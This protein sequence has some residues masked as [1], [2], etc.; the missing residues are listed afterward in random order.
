MAHN[1]APSDIVTHTDEN[2]KPNTA[3]P[4]DVTTK[5][6]PTAQSKVSQEL[7]NADSK[8]LKNAIHPIFQKQNW[9][10][11]AQDAWPLLEPALRLASRLIS[12]DEMLAFWYHLVW[13][14]QKLQVESENCGHT[15]EMFSAEGPPLTTAQ[16]RRTAYWLQGFRGKRHTPFLNFQAEKKWARTVK[17]ITDGGITVELYSGLLEPLR[18]QKKFF[19]DANA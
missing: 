6:K 4:E 9:E 18:G 14:R 1:L 3:S 16:K 12:E 11:P 2:A 5:K 19:R 15:L 13:G 8:L 17:C 7:P 10:Q